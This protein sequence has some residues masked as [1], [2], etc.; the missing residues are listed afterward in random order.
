LI[1]P[2][3]QQIQLNDTVLKINY[4]LLREILVNQ[5]NFQSFEKNVEELRKIMTKPQQQSLFG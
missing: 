3:L 2:G 1:V 5:H 4:E